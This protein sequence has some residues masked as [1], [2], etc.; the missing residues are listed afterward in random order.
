MNIQEDLKNFLAQASAKINIGSEKLEGLV[1]S[2]TSDERVVKLEGIISSLN[3]KGFKD[4]IST[5]VGTGENQPINPDK[6][7]EA[8][9]VNKIEELAKQA[10][11]SASEVPQALAS[12]LPQLIDKLTPDGKEPENGITAQAVK[13][14][15]GIQTKL[16]G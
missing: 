12:V 3:E 14:L 6:I 16:N 9:G 15:K 4:T 2:I 13:L 7:K 11:M 8:L 5:W 10:K 1:A